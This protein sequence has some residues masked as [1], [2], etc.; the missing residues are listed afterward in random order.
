M[1]AESTEDTR[2]DQEICGGDARQRAPSTADHAM[3]SLSRRLAPGDPVGSLAADLC[4]TA[5]CE[6]MPPEEI[7]RTAA[8]C[9][10]AAEICYGKSPLYEQI[11]SR[12]PADAHDAERLRLLRERHAREQSGGIDPNGLTGKS[13]FVPPYATPADEAYGLFS[14]H[15]PV[16]GG[17]GFDHEGK[18][19]VAAAAD[20]A[21][22]APDRGF[23]DPGVEGL[24]ARF[25]VPDCEARSPSGERCSKPPYHSGDHVSENES[26]SLSRVFAASDG[27]EPLQEEDAKAEEQHFRDLGWTPEGGNL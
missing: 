14:P 18:P 24:P 1:K 5:I 17:L 21:V 12:E 26:W 2:D 15:H 11:V 27:A 16:N 7:E 23:I 13:P 10:R 20:D 8:S 6:A 22:P 3:Q 25:A 19:I 4:E 9:R